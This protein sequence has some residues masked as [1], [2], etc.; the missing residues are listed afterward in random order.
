MGA[1]GGFVYLQLKDETAFRALTGWLL[2]RVL[3]T[4]CMSYSGSVND[5][6]EPDGPPTSW[7]HWIEGGCGTDC[8]HDLESLQ[9]VAEWCASPRPPH[10]LDGNSDIRDYTF[11]ELKAAL[12]SDPEFDLW[13]WYE[14]AFK[15]PHHAW[16][17]WRPIGFIVA[18]LQAYLKTQVPRAD[19]YIQGPLPSGTPYGQDVP[20]EFRNMTLREW[21]TKVHAL[22]ISSFSEET[23]T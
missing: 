7:A 5:F 13:T 11:E 6:C 23:W 18:D 2:W 3:N 10:I 19:G 9:E 16:W 17:N 4:S 15:P 1:E 8:D 12:L 22:I 21:G 14:R 20:P